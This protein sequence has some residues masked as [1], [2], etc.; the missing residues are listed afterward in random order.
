MSTADKISGSGDAVP[1]V[2]G[3]AVRAGL[4]WVSSAYGL[5]AVQMVHDRASAALRAVIVPGLSSFGIL[6]SGWYSLL[7]IG[8][9]LDGIV[10]ATAPTNVDLHYRRMAAAVA[11]DNVTGVYRALLRLVA[12]PSLLKAHGP[13]VW[14]NYYSHG[15]IE[16]STERPG[17]LTIAVRDAPVHHDAMCRMTGLVVERILG[18]V[19]YRNATLG[20]VRCIGRGSEECAFVIDYAE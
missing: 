2:K 11:H 4:H 8:E 17:E 15:T 9:L 10:E 3:V 12:T 1:T 16:V 19:G 14:R 6:S 20:R 5:S 13:R 18:E 7:L